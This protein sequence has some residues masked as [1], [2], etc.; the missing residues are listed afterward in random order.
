MYLNSCF[1]ILVFQ[2]LSF[3][4]FW[5]CIYS[6]TFFW[7]WVMYSYLFA[8]FIIFYLMPYIV[9]FYIIEARL[10]YIPFNS[11]N[12]C[13]GIQLEQCLPLDIGEIG[14]LVTWVCSCHKIHQNIYLLYVHLTPTKLHSIKLFFK[15]YTSSLKIFK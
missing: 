8:C 15:H 12:L 1:T 5:F 4:H 6:L 7:L 13:S 14:V 9:K 10:C 2:F 11:V 3:C